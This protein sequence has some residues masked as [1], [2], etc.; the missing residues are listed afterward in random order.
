MRKAIIAAIVAT[1]LFAVGAFAASFT[2][3]AEETA[4]GTDAVAQ[5]TAN[6]DIK[7]DETFSPNLDDWFVA[8]VDV[9]LDTGNTCGGSEVTLILQAEDGTQVLIE[10]T[11]ASGTAGG[12]VT[13]ALIEIPV[14]CG[15][16]GD[17]CAGV[18]G[19]TQRLLVSQVWNAAVLLD[20]V[21]YTS[22]G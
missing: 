17:S 1:A 8:N 2:L 15:D 4:S 9:T 16:T 5:C 19:T 7:F 6:V 20:G 18:D 12:E 21:E 14:D 11:V 3:S 22:L 13:P 10:E